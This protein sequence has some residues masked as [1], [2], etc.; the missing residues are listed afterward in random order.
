MNGTA[1]VERFVML[2]QIGKN[3][4]ALTAIATAAIA[5]IGT[6]FIAS[7]LTIFDWSLVWLIE[8]S[9]IAK[10][11][12]L[13]VALASGSAVLI[14]NFVDVIYDWMTTHDRMYKWLLFS[15]AAIP[16]VYPRSHY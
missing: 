1:D 15:F 4:A 10:I 7:Y 9:D 16:L 6:I 14:Y 12:I 11:G 3:I 5:M 2:E 8:Y 13:G